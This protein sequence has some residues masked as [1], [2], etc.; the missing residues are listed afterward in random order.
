MFSIEAPLFNL[1]HVI[2]SKNSI[3]GLCI[4]YK[5][6]GMCDVCGMSPLMLLKELN[7]YSLMN[8]Y[9]LIKHRLFYWFNFLYYLSEIDKREKYVIQSFMVLS[10]ILI[11]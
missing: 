6:L 1:L 9:S 4:L 8:C 10:Q 11:L 2:T 5:H 3:A 7:F